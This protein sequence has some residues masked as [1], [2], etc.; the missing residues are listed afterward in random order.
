MEAGQISGTYGEL[1]GFSVPVSG[2]VR[3]KKLL[4]VCIYTVDLV[5]GSRLHYTQDWT[6][7][8]DAND[9]RSFRNIL[10]SG[11]PTP[12][13]AE[14]LSRRSPV[15]HLRAVVRETG[16]HQLLEIWD[17]HGLRKCLDLTSLS[18]HG[19]V[20]DEAQFGCL[21]WSDCEN[22]VLYVA[23]KAKERSSDPDRNVYRE[24]WGEALTNQSVPVIC[25]VDLRSG[26][27]SV[28]E[29]VPSDVSAGQA[30][31]APGGQSLYFVGWYHEPFRLGLKFCSN[32]RSALF[33]L[34]LNGNCERLSEDNVSVSCPRL[35]PDGSTII[36]LQ[37]AVFGPHSQCLSLQQMD[38]KRMKTSTLIEVVDRPQTGE[39]AGVYE[40]LASCCW[41]EDGQRVVFSSA[42]RNYRDVFVVDRRS[43]KVSSISDSKI[44]S[45]LL[46]SSPSLI[47]PSPPSSPPSPQLPPPPSPFWSIHL[48]PPP[49]PFPLPLPPVLPTSTLPS[50]CSILTPLPPPPLPLSAPPLSAESPFLIPPPPPPPPSLLPSS[51][52]ENKMQ[53][54]ESVRVYGGWK[55]LTIHRDLMV[56][57]CSSPNTPP[58]LRV[59]FLPSEGEPV[60]WYTLQ[61]PVKSYDFHWTSLDVVPSPEEDNSAYSGLD[62]GAVL[63]KP[64]TSLTEAKIPVVVFIHGG[65]HSQFPA[66]W[67]CTTSG[68]VL[69]GFAVLMV[70]YRG[71]TGFGQDS[72]LSLIGQIGSQDVKDVQRAVLTALQTDPALDPKR[73]AVIGGSHGGFLTCH[74]LGQYPDF[75][76]AGASRNP[77]INAAT[78]LG[79]SDIMDWRYT[80]VGLQFSYDQIPSAVALTTML[81]RSP[82]THAAQI[83]APVLLMLGAKDRRVSPHQGLELYKAL[84][85]RGSDV[86]VLWFPDDGHSLSRVDTQADCFLS[87]VLWLQQHL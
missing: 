25:V 43:K 16:G 22:K 75:Y 55:L 1:S 45:S 4:E 58:T 34:D 85:S 76:R 57:C 49:P 70:N 48:P 39:F 19:R 86:R 67:N 59:G 35:C 6:L 26:T 37:G 18:K 23:E 87:T 83:K 40:A 14:L 82:I 24:D 27:L 52:L 65:P 10:P 80:S 62:F 13:S 74:L 69:L 8:S 9:H 20:Y 44:P 12:V 51:H 38:L 73:L 3:E 46:C 54:Q 28:L 5:R 64:T 11:P 30:L 29:G 50:Q 32:R 21:S 56:V 36:Y 2:E 33:R 84:K 17:P 15:G 63:V 78:L 66:E 61:E 77:V 47:F 81:Q 68:L 42:C 60:N 41:S 53:H 7:I 72:I 79:T 71:S 31:W